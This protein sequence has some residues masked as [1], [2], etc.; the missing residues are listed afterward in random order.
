MGGSYILFSFVASNAI[1]KEWMLVTGWMAVGA[2]AVLILSLPEIG[3]KVAAAALI[4]IGVTLLAKEFLRRRQQ[5]L[6]EKKS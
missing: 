6:N 4:S 1:Q 5:Y 3:A 2:A